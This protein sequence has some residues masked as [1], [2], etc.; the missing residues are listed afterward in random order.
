MWKEK[1]KYW[2]DNFAST[3]MSTAVVRITSTVALDFGQGL[4]MR[5]KYP[6]RPSGPQRRQACYYSMQAA[7]GVHTL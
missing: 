3:N 4:L 7:N 6:G 1:R 2:T 5:Q